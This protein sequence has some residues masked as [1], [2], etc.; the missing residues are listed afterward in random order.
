MISTK[1]MAMHVFISLIQTEL[2]RYE[3]LCGNMRNTG[4]QKITQQ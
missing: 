3:N 1:Y 4:N 2:E